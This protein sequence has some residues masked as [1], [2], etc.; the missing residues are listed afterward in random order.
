MIYS[1]SPREYRNFLQGAQLAKIDE[2]E[3]QVQSAWIGGMVS[4][5]KKS[6]KENPP[7][8]YF[9]AEKARKEVLSGTNNTKQMDI[10]FT[11]YDQM[12]EE[13]K[14]FNWQRVEKKS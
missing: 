12:R 8:K 14:T 3:R 10:D 9:D 7:K 5:Q 1:W 4:K 6:R 11:L 2:Y 13:L